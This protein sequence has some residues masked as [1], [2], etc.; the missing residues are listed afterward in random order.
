MRLFEYEAKAIFSKCGI[1]IPRGGLGSNPEQVRRIAEEIGRPVA[2]KAQVLVGGRQKAGGVRFAA[3]P[4]E[5]AKT[6]ARIFTEGVGS[7]PVRKLLVEE[8]LDFEREIY[9]AITIDGSMGGPIAMVSSEGGIEIE[10]IVAKYPERLVAE[11]IDV[12]SGLEQH[13]A[14]KLT[15]RIGLPKEAMVNVDRILLVLYKI[16]KKY[17]GTTAE[18]NPLIIDRGGAAYAVGAVL[19]VD[20]DALFRHPE[21][22]AKLDQ[23]VEDEI[24]RRASELGLAY[25]RLDGDIGL[26]GTGAGL[27]I[28]TGDLVR[29][30][31]GEPANFLD[32]GGRVTQ[33]HIKNALS[34]VLMNPKVR[35]VLIN[36]YGGINPIVDAARGIVTIAKERRLSM[37]IVVKVRGNFEEE[38]W[39]ILQDAGIEIVKDIRTEVA[40]RRI[41]ELVQRCGKR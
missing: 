29:L 22:E 20:D 26:I 8:R 33:E 40:A 21:M 27:A 19:D 23:R 3:D 11:R 38:A 7:I 6:A 36:M 9:V 13:Q 10:D 37:P 12:F 39:R 16:F 17:D 14:R 5:A 18:I 25:V 2:L 30:Y 1:S 31:G 35:G 15:E 34:I 24:E 28:A 32:T 41:T 4:T